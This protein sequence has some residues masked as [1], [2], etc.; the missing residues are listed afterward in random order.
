[1]ENKLIRTIKGTPKHLFRDGNLNSFTY[2][3]INLP[4]KCNFRCKKCFNLENGTPRKYTSLI[5]LEERLDLINQ[6]KEIGGKVVVFA[7]EG[8]P[9]LD[10]NIKKMVEYVNNLNMISIIYSNGSTLTKQ[11]IE[12]YKENNASLIFSF[13]T[14]QENLFSMKSLERNIF[15]KT[16]INITRA[17]DSFK[18]LIHEE[19]GLEVLSVGVNSTVNDLNLG[20]IPILKSLWGEDAYYICNPIAKLGNAI[21]NWSILKREN[22]EDNLIME[23]IKENSETGGPL[24]LTETGLCGYSKNGIS[25]SPNGDYMTCAYTN[26]TDGFFGNIKEIKLKKAWDRKY[27]KELDYYKKYGGAPCL[28]RSKYF[29]EYLNDLK[30]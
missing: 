2:L 25:I 14:L 9:N 18:E 5:S 28:I 15:P 20:E 19:N 1:M 3:M 27:K 6:T 12:F 16:I 21:N 17:V 24:T 26:L 29:N 30:L 4:F 22:I 8:E 13:D 7:G 10:K 11:D 23:I